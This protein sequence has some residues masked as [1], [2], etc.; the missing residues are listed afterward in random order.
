MEGNSR[1]K[2]TN[3]NG[4]I[5]SQE[6]IKQSD[7]KKRQHR[8]LRQTQVYR[9]MSNLKYT[10]VRLSGTTPRRY[11]K[12]FDVMLEHVSQAKISL[13]IGLSDR[14]LDN[15]YDNMSYSLALTEDIQDD[16]IILFSLN[17]ISKKDKK[18]IRVLAHKV[19]GQIVRLRDYF[20]SQGMDVLGK[21]N[22]G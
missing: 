8:T 10:I 14:D 17:V 6:T 4:V 9:D 20:G 12:Y 1:V 19:T 3:D 11:A 7:E 21:T 16:A 18:Q 22:N 2:V 13:A 15:R 5:I